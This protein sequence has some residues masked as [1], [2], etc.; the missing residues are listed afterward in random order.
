M[1][2]GH[3]YESPVLPQRELESYPWVIVSWGKENSQ[4]FQRMLWM[5][6]LTS[7]L[8]YYHGPSKWVQGRLLVESWSWATYSGLIYLIYACII[9]IDIL[10]IWHNSHGLDHELLEW[11]RQYYSGE[12]MVKISSTLKNLNTFAKVVFE[13]CLHLGHQYSC[14]KTKWQWQPQ[15]QPWPW[16]QWPC[17][18][19]SFCHD[20]DYHSLKFTVGSVD[21]ANVFSF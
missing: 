10:G 11:G 18:M 17:Q 8:E 21:L 16:P 4:T 12:K 1:A 7:C 3:S 9:R 15:T 13:S 19:Q 6:G 14:L 5:K 2:N 20:A